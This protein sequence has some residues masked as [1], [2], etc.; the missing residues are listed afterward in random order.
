[1]LF[2]APVAEIKGLL[3]FVCFVFLYNFA[4]DMSINKS[5][6]KYLFKS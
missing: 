5:S 6:Y 4:C 1:M 3:I 2:K